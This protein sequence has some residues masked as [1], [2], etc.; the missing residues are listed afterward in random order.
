MRI[1][2]LTSNDTHGSNAAAALSLWRVGSIVQAT[3]LRDATT[4]QLWLKLGE[5]RLP[6]RVASGHPQ[7]PAD[8]EQLKLRVL[9][10]SP[11]L[12]F[13]VLETAGG[14]LSG[15][16]GDLLGDALRRHL[17]RQSTP[18]PLLA[19]LAWQARN[20][21]AS[22]ALPK[23]VT[24]ALMRI[25]ESLPRAPA[26]H[27]PQELADVI[28]KSGVFLESALARSGRFGERADIANRDFKALLL[29]LKKEL[30]AQVP[31]APATAAASGPLPMLRGPLTAIGATPA[32]LA[33][34][35]AA[36]AQ[37][38]ELAQ[39]TE[40][41]LA[42]I[43]STQLLNAE[44][45]RTD[46]PLWLVEIPLRQEDRAELLRLRFEREAAEAEHLPA[47]WSVEVAMDLGAAGQLHARISL[48][49][50]RCTVQLRSESPQL[51]AAL[52]RDA[53]AL[54]A[55]LQAAGLLI[56][57]IICLHGAPVGENAPPMRLLDFHA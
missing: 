30:A 11:V 17:P 5:R 53:Q 21:A 31:A 43:T 29:A 56:D 36:P 32:T 54:T 8:G 41:A 7:G 20:G 33:L 12:A 40:G 9:R 46:A 6:M 2:L 13:E 51:I 1:D 25:W 50:R 22:R 47:R 44:S 35:D 10:D 27:T 48:Q 42:R 15:T 38:Q 18:M 28:A 37:M 19:N 23:Q 45:A 24:E 34:M 26:L 16:G 49:E 52:N 14:A 3:V 55:A 57:R 39:Q 4:G